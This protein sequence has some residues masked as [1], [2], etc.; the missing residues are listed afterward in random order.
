[1]GRIDS[2]WGRSGALVLAYAVME[3]TL[4]AGNGPVAAN[5][6]AVAL[7]ARWRGR[8]QLES[9]AVSLSGGIEC[10]RRVPRCRRRWDARAFVGEVEGT[11]LEV[12]SP[13]S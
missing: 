12:D 1:M 5:L 8:D 13:L 10:T 3:R 9:R 6:E 4:L 11:K 7:E 2:H